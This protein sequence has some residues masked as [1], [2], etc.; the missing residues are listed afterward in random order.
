MLQHVCLVP[1]RPSLPPP[2]P[3]GCRGIR[4]W[5]SVN[6]SN[7]YLV[8]GPL[9]GQDSLVDPAGGVLQMPHYRCVAGMACINDDDGLLAASSNASSTVYPFRYVEW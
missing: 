4:H 6:P 1:V 2:L 7:S 3:A 5:D 8:C 9:W